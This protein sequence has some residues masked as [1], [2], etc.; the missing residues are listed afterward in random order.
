[1]NLWNHIEN[2]VSY[3]AVYDNS[4]IEALK[5]AKK[6]NFAGIQ[7]AV[8]SPHLSFEHLSHEKRVIIKNFCKNNGL[9]INLHAPD[10][11]SLL[12][13]N[14]QI[15]NGIFE[16]FMALFTF[17]NDISSQIVTIHIGSMTTFP[18]DTTPERIY[19]D[20]DLD[21]YKNSLKK[22]LKH[23]ISL[24]D[25]QIVLCIENYQINSLF[26]DILQ[27]YISNKKC[28]LC[29]DVAKAFNNKQHKNIEVTNFFNKNQKSIKQIHL[30]DVNENGRGHRIIGSGLIDFKEFLLNIKNFPVIDYCIEVRPRSK[31]LESLKNLKQILSSSAQ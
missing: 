2:K 25:E 27:P 3:H 10:D 19:P 28:W 18:T 31:A 11:I 20:E 24:L 4:I 7:L 29:Y 12:N 8:E 30:H 6:N 5:F 23:L 9:Y 15:Q 16:Y 22:N 17:A 13:T 26:L 1:M 21:L 14:P